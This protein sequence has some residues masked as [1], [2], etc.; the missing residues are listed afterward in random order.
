MSKLSTFI[1]ILNIFVTLDISNIKEANYFY[2]HNNRLYQFRPSYELDSY[3]IHEINNFT[4]SYD[5]GKILISNSLGEILLVFNID[6]ENYHPVD[7]E[8]QFVLEHGRL[9]FSDIDEKYLEHILN[10]IRPVIESI[11]NSNGK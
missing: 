4:L 8:V 9:N 10:G 7:D 5:V 6:K 11:K 3:F 1:D 2:E